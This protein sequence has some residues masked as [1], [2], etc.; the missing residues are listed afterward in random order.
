MALPPTTRAGTVDVVVPVYNEQ[1]DLAGSV[2]RLH[3]Y[4][5]EHLPYPFR[6]TIAD[7]A[8]TDATPDIAEGL[9]AE[10]AEVTSVRL[11][12]KGRGGAL[13]AVW[14]ASDAEVLAYCDADLST[15]LAALP[16]LVAPLM[17]GHSELAIGT[18]L[19]RGATVVRCA[20]REVLSRG[21]NLILRGCLGARFSDAQCGFKAIRA[22]AARLLLPLAEDTGW[23]FDTELLVLAE[24]A[25]LRIHEVPVDWVEDRR[26]SVDLVPTVLADLRGM[27]RL[28]WGGL[29]RHA[30]GFTLVGLACTAL[31]LLLFL[32]LRGPLGVLPG[33]GVALVLA[34]LANTAA[35]RRFTFGLRGYRH[36]TRHHGQ[37]LALLVAGIGLTSGALAL[38]RWCWPLAP[39]AAQLAVLL[40]TGLVATAARFVVFRRWA[41][42]RDRPGRVAHRPPPAVPSQRVGASGGERS[43]S[44]RVMR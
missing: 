29:A 26:S 4:L 17:S 11:E 12:R 44:A 35:N 41:P 13:R 18:R 31:H 36:L 40:F 43:P 9:A 30:A 19:A 32:I 39:T 15:D 1:R 20:K 8:S 6:I 38:L 25:G 33:N 37:G 28:A 21:Y 5:R 10:L 34:T 24:R 2:R 14:A 16:V 3:A 27:C 22:D 42:G 7:N 23:F